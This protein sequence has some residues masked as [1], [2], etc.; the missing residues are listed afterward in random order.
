MINIPQVHDLPSLSVYEYTKVC[1]LS[2]AKIP[3]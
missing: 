2:G 3:C 1:L